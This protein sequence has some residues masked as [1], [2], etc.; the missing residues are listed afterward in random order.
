MKVLHL[1]AAER[2]SVA[3]WDGELACG[4]E[5]T[6]SAQGGESPGFACCIPRIC[7][8]GRCSIL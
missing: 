8:V 7:P 2:V 1:I 5:K 4:C 3:A 6:K